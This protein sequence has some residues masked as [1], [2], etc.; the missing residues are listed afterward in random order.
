VSR[1]TAHVEPEL[2]RAVREAL[3]RSA[4]FDSRRTLQTLGTAVGE[5]LVGY[6]EPKLIDLLVAVDR[7]ATSGAPVLS[8]LIEAEG[9][10]PLPCLGSV[11]ARLGLGQTSNAKIFSAWRIRERQRA[12]AQYTATPRAIPPR[13]LLPRLVR[14]QSSIAT[15]TRPSP[16]PVSRMSGKLVSASQNPEV[17]VVKVLV[18]EAEGVASEAGPQ[19]RDS[20][21]TAIRDARQWLRTVQR[22]SDGDIAVHAKRYGQRLTAAVV[23][24]RMEE[25]PGRSH[26]AMREDDADAPHGRRGAGDK[27]E[28]TDGDGGH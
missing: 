16:E 10:Q 20:L 28:H 4:R 9:R 13:I 21:E 27:I 23:E 11:V 14:Q 5:P 26:G 6:P 17:E 22:S 15:G 19:H 1:V 8:V 2:I 12:L 25:G 3:I 7:D 24:A 18:T